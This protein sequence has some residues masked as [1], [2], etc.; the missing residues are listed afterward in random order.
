M[1]KKPLCVKELAH[2]K[3]ENGEAN[4]ISAIATMFNTDVI[5][6]GKP[7]ANERVRVS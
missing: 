7:Y 5:A 2:G 3:A 4:W 6:S 1:K